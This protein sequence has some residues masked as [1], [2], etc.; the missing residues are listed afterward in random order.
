MARIR[1]NK[2]AER[3]QKFKLELVR[4][5]DPVQAHE[6]SGHPPVRALET[7][8]DLGFLWPEDAA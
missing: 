7:M 6:L 1:E 4:T 5:G 8:R 3:E 2:R